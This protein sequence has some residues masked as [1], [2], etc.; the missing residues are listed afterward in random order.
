MPQ[1][2]CTVGAGILS[3]CLM[4]YSRSASAVQQRARFNRELSKNEGEYE[5]LN[6]DESTALARPGLA[7]QLASSANHSPCSG[8]IGGT[9]QPIF[10]AVYSSIHRFST[11]LSSSGFKF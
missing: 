2:D 4:A 8:T 10:L 1:E 3:A 5:I 6:V 11:S 7:E 9:P